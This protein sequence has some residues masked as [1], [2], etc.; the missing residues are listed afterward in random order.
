MGR[1]GRR[2]GAGR[3]IGSR[4]P[5]GGRPMGSINRMSREMREAARRTGLLPHEILLAICQGRAKE[6][7]GRHAT[8]EE[9]IDAAKAAAPFYAPKLIA[10]AVKAIDN[11]NPYEELLR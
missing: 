2:E 3:K 6:V 11:A 8:V 9:R 7:L 1:G 5:R 10:V 4:N